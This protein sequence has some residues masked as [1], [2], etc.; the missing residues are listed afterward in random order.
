MEKIKRFLEPLK[1]FPYQYW[2]LIINTAFWLILNLATIRMIGTISDLILLK[3]ISSIYRYSIYYWCIILWFYLLSFIGSW[4]SRRLRANTVTYI[5]TKYQK[6]I[7]EL[8]NNYFEWLGTG[9]VISI[10]DSWVFT[11]TE[12][13]SQSIYFWFW[14]LITLIW[15]YY[16]ISKIGLYPL[17]FS[18]FFLIISI[19]LFYCFN[20]ILNKYKKERKELHVLISKNTIKT[21]MSKFE[22]QL[23]NNMKI[24][25]LR[26]LIISKLS[27]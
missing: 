16:F 4:N 23:N 12:L 24:K 5:K 2:L 8:D 11:R 13:I 26:V 20:W 15:S 6:K 18:I 19:I 22:V 17:L 3:D 10:L 7:I 14:S 21:I 25:Y 1:A 9:K 27:W